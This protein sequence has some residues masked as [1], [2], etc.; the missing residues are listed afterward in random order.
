MEKLLE[1]ALIKVTTVA[2]RIGTMSVRD[3]LEAQALQAPVGPGKVIVSCALSMR[4]CA[5][6]AAS[7]QRASNDRVAGRQ[8]AAQCSTSE[9]M[10]RRLP[11]CLF[12]ANVAVSTKGA[13]SPRACSIHAK[14]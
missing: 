7:R 3:T 2:S 10:A 8:G 12:F 14:S 11:V 13:V 1:D 5:Q 9:S 4:S 6:G